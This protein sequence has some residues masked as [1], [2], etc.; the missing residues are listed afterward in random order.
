MKLGLGFLFGIA[1][2]A[3]ACGA[4]APP[5]KT[6][7]PQPVAAPFEPEPELTAWILLEGAQ[8][9]PWPLTRWPRRDTQSTLASHCAGADADACE[10]ALCYASRAQYDEALSERA[11]CVSASDELDTEL[12]EV[13]AGHSLADPA[14]DRFARQPERNIRFLD[15]LATTLMAFD[16]RFVARDVAR[17]VDDLDPNPDRE[18]A[19]FRRLRRVV[20]MRHDEDAVGEALGKLDSADCPICTEA[21]DVEMCTST[22]VGIVGLGPSEM[23]DRIVSQCAPYLK[24]HPDEAGVIELAAAYFSWSDA[25]PRYLPDWIAIARHAL[26]AGSSVDALS[27]GAAALENAARAIDCAKTDELESI[28]SVAEEFTT[29]KIS[30]A[31]RARFESIAHRCGR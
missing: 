19:C 24:R 23:G 10:A 26:A 12:A 1:M 18:T 30:P 5:A 29:H 6:V 13:L 2:V 7:H 17:E 21:I 3:S 8:R 31:F 28:I 27:L 11:R 4:T 9:P 16:R 25:T 20:W 15:A 14:V 22:F